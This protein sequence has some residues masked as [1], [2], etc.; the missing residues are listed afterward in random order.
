MY[1]EN[2]LDGDGYNVKTVHWIMG[3]VTGG[4]HVLNQISIYKVN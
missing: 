4:S 1:Y 3:N 2:K